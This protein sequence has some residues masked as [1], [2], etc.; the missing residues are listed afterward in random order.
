MNVLVIGGGGR[1]HALV[2]AVKKS[3]GIEKVYCSPGNAGIAREAACVSLDLKDHASVAAFVKEKGI[4]LTLIG[5]EAPLVDG[6]AD[7]LRAA[8]HRV[9]G[10][11]KKAA[12]LEGSKVVAKEFMR[13]HGLP[14]AD[15]R[16]FEKGAEALAYVRSTDY[17]PTF[18]IVKAS[19]LAAGKGV[20]VAKSAEEVLSA[21]DDMMVRKVFG[22]AGDQVVLEET[23][24]G[25]EL[26]VIALCDGK[27]LVP[28]LPTQDH[29]RAL[30]ND[31]GPNTGGMGA[32]GPVPQVSPELWARIESEVCAP[33]VK[34]LQVDGL[35]YRGVIFFG[36]MLTRQGPKLLEFNVRFGDPETQVIL[37][38]IE[39]DWLDL[40]SAVA[41]GRL[42]AVELRRR[43]GAG[44]VVVMAAH[45]YP[46][47]PRK[48]DVIEGLEEAGVVPGVTV[49]HAGTALKD[50]RVATSGGRVL[51]VT[52]V[53]KDL[54]EA[55][56]NAYAAVEKI[57]FAGAHFRRDIGAKAF[58]A[59]DLYN[60]TR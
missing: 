43:P 24:E 31:E 27:T 21:L 36:L 6:L 57:R 10:V 17:N 44:I 33:F 45:N 52:A 56:H 54:A 30:D 18:R 26:S 53:G 16:V 40:F 34:G 7:S 48:G 49:F 32:Y 29:K 22:A 1:E 47:E 50:G 58:H 13:R 59:A 39:N 35:D 5:P 14:T 60:R 28:L 19:G 23:L 55:R 20:V 38:M 12:A 8:G 9:F 4:S 42:G 41:D 2:W 25:E 37:P 51:G 3:R 11:G 15:Y 46:A